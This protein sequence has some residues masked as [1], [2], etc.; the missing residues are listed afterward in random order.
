MSEDPIKEALEQFERIQPYIA[1]MGMSVGFL[2][3][4]LS[5]E[6]RA[7][8]MDMVDGAPG[9]HAKI[10]EWA[11]EF[12]EEWEKRE[13][14]MDPDDLADFPDQITAFTDAKIKALIAEARLTQ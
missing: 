4:Q 1:Q 3:N 10:I 7:A 13:A 9:L 5:A 6:A 12:D 8:V 14:I 2:W 11:E